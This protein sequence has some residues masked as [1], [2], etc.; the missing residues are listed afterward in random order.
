MLIARISSIVLS[1]NINPWFLSYL[2]VKVSLRYTSEY[3]K[4]F[5]SV[6]ELMGFSHTKWFLSC[7]SCMVG[8]NTLALEIS[9]VRLLLE[10]DPKNCHKYV[11]WEDTQAVWFF[12]LAF[13]LFLMLLQVKYNVNSPTIHCTHLLETLSWKSRPC[14]LLQ[15]KFFWESV[16]PH[17]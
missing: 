16:S 10:W 17:F 12:W 14:H 5:F 8:V 6:S 7:L 9:W 3:T 13:F 15:I 1:M 11:W 2:I 4:R